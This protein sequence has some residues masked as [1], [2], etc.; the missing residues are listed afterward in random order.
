VCF[1]VLAVGDEKLPPPTHFS[2]ALS[3]DNCSL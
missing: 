2:D 3:L 1:R